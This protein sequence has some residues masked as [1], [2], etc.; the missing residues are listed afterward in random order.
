M[1]RD[2]G[3]LP[4][5]I[6]LVSLI[7]QA[8]LHLRMP[9]ARLLPEPLNWSGIGV[10]ALGI[11]IIAGPALDFRRSETTIIPFR[12]SSSLVVTG[13]YRLTRNPMYLGMVTILI[14]VATLTGSLSPFVVPVLFVPVLNARVIRHE[15][16]MLEEKFGDQYRDYMQRVR[17]W[18]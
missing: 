15:E 17:R 6:L 11:G 3:P 14:G 18:L 9:L 2:R 1:T 16:A 10:L 7:V 12:E 5:V 8:G 4:P 13:M